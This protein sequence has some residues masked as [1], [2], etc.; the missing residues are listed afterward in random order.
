M[1][2]IPE[3]IF[4][5]D[6]TIVRLRARQDELERQLELCESAICNREA[7]IRS[8]LAVDDESIRR[9]WS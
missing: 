5:T 6:D 9:L 2:D 7:E 3:D 4:R 1:N 8:R